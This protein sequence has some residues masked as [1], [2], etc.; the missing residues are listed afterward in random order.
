MPRHPQQPDAPGKAAEEA[1]VLFP[2]VDVEVRDP[3]TG[4]ALTLTVREFR[5]LDGLKAQ[6]EAAGLIAALRTLVE[7][8][9]APSM[10]GV[11]A[12]QAA[13]AD[14]WLALLARATGREAAWLERLPDVDGHAL[15]DALW[16]ANLPFF[17]SRLLAGVSPPTP[18]GASESP[19]SSATSSP[20]AT[21]ATSGRSR[22]ASPSGRS[23]S[24]GAA[25][26]GGAASSRS[27]S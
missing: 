19:G 4:E 16:E 26:S 25:P 9:Q 8:A 15:G 22:S 12:V 20:P 11:M 14:E 3:D 7:D 27:R 13:H 1:G 17:V 18:G 5:L 2:D 23:S 24:P 10:E 21:G 6:G